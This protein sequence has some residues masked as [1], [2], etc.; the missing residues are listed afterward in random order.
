[1]NES[2]L[3]RYR[4]LA[5]RYLGFDDEG[6]RGS[7]LEILNPWAFTFL[8]QGDAMNIK[9]EAAEALK[10]LDEAEAKEFDWESNRDDENPK[11]LP[12]PEENESK[13]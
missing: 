9:Y 12:W 4:F 6:L 10:M 5:H 8:Y 11:D 7:K 2:I 3:H 13:E 1:M